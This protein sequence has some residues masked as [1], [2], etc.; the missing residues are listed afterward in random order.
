MLKLGMHWEALAATQA[1][2]KIDDYLVGR[3]FAIETVHKPLIPIL[4]E[5]DLCDLPI[6]V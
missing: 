6:R 4:G 5:K 3:K 1:C 2:E